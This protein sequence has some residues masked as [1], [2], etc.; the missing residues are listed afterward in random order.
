MKQQQSTL[1]VKKI[2]KEPKEETEQLPIK[3]KTIKK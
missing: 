2:K 1:K 3:T